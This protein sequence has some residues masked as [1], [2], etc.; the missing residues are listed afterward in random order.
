MQDR[1]ECPE[2][3]IGVRLS[4]KNILP[5]VLGGAAMRLLVG[6]TGVGR[7]EGRPEAAVTLTAMVFTQTA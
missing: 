6:N 4:M 7:P 5:S 2:N 3:T 1:I